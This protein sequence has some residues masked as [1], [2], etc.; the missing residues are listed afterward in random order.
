MENIAAITN[1]VEQTYL[2]ATAKEVFCED[3]GYIA[4]AEELLPD[5]PPLSGWIT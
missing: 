2:Q 4:N 1:V 3:A 5:Q